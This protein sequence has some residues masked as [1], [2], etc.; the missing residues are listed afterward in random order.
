M[1]AAALRGRPLGDGTYALRIDLLERTAAA[2]V[3]HRDLPGPL[4]TPTAVRA[5]SDTSPADAPE[6]IEARCDSLEQ[7]L[8]QRLFDQL[9]SMS[10]D[11]EEEEEEEEVEE[12]EESAPHCPDSA[13]KRP[14]TA[15]NLAAP[16][17]EK[18]RSARIPAREW[19]LTYLRDI[20]AMLRLISPLVPPSAV[21]FL[22]SA[23][24]GL[25]T[26]LDAEVSEA[27]GAA[28]RLQEELARRDPADFTTERL[29][30]QL[31]EVT[32]MNE[33]LKATLTDAQARLHEEN[34]S[35]KEKAEQLSKRVSYSN[36]DRGSGEGSVASAAGTPNGARAWPRQQSRGSERSSRSGG[37]STRL[38]PRP[39]ARTLSR[40][41]L[42]PR[43]CT[44]PA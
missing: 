14:D 35:K 39:V 6:Q 30:C 28:K 8:V 44:R 1:N 38:P 27:R 25:V 21:R 40:M 31:K 17:A 13:A 5:S 4:A 34:A 16:G 23:V 32:A 9:R 11:P 7:G 19:G 29:R 42:D 36:R 41:S 18:L 3:L 2:V 24:K 10:A 12:P 37:G 15:D 43:P 33:E 20:R 26:A 22:E